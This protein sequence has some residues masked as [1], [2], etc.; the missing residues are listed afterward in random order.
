MW[1]H[2]S[3]DCIVENILH[4]NKTYGILK[5]WAVEATN[6]VL[7]FCESCQVVTN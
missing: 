3:Q 6:K 7:K 1:G 4:G 2:Y 5:L